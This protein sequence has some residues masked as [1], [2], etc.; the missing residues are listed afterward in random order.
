MNQ[1]AGI[2]VALVVGAMITGASIVGV[3]VVR[4]E[5]ELLT[6]LAGLVGFGI[7]A[8]AFA[9]IFQ[10][11]VRAD[12]SLWALGFML[13]SAAGGYALASTLLY[14]FGTRPPLPALPDVLPEDNGKP[15][16]ILL[17]CIEPESYDPRE[18]AQMLQSLADE[19]LLDASIGILPF[20]FFAQKARYRVVADDSPSA[21]QLTAVTQRLSTTMNSD[22]TFSIEWV[23]CSGNGALTSAVVRAAARGH[24]TIVV[25]ELFV[26]EPPQVGDEKA[27]M[28]ALRLESKGID[29]RF[30]GVLSDSNRLL[31]MLAERV[32]EAMRPDAGVVLVGHGQPDE[33]ARINP[34]FDEQETT[35][36]SR[37]RMLLVERGVP[38]DNVRIAWADWGDPD[39]TSSVRHL[40]ARG[41]PKVLV[42]PA[43]YPFDS[44]ATRLD[45]ELAVRQARIDESAVA[46]TMAPWRD[47]EV[48]AE[49]LRS[50]IV[51]ALDEQEGV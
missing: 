29:V 22:D 24:R 42:L 13:A 10:I 50:R 36:L 17:A 20:L 51:A 4:R 27:A 45:L 5:L 16:V 15:A 30:T 3:L 12:A 38:E 46:T 49:A 28:Q 37:L 41:C 2:W 8:F 7:T 11:F 9:E 23:P 35:F 6:A 31:G 25:A 40:V 44:V 43:V 33:R 26:A 18:T 32:M 48:V 14:R 39:V 47:D 34:D 1:M 19:D 21:A